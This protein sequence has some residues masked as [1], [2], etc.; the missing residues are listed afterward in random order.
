MVVTLRTALLAIVGTLGLLVVGFSGL[1]A[2]DAF[3]RYRANARFIEANDAS[4]VLLKFATN[5]AIERG[6]SNAPLHAADALPADQMREI[7][8]IRA[9]SDETLPRALAQLRR[10]PALAASLQT[11]DEL[12]DAYRVFDKFR[13]EVDQNLARKQNER[14]TDVVEKLAPMLT[15][16]IDRTEKVRTILEALVTSPEADLAQLVHVRT[17]VAEMA[18]Q[19]GRERDIF[20]GNISQ[21]APFTDD[22][23]RKVSEHRG[24]IELVWTALQAFRLRPDLPDAVTAAIGQVG[25]AYIQKLT[26][27]RQ[28]VLA[29]AGLG[30]YPLSGREWID[31]SGV[32]IGTIS[33]LTDVISAKAHDAAGESASAALRNLVLYLGLMAFGIAVSIFSFGIVTRYV[34]RPLAGVTSAMR[35]LAEGDTAV[36][37][38]GQ[39]RR[40]E[41]GQMAKAVDV[42][43]RNMIEADRLRADREDAERRAE[44]EKRATMNR[45]ADEFEA[46]VKGIVQSVSAA[47][48]E[49]RT[50]AQSM[51]T[52]AEQTEHRS[53]VVATAAEHASGNVEAVAAAAQE[54]SASVA[55]VGRQ[56]GESTG[57][58]RLA[59]EDANRTNTQ[60]QTLAEA[61][62]KIG[63]VVKLINDIAGQTNLLALN[64]TIEAARA[65]EAG[66]GFAVVASE[67]KTL[68]SQTAKATD[69][70]GGL[71][72][73]IQHA[74]GES[75][76]AIR[77]VGRTIG[78]TSEIATAIASAI[79]EQTA[80]ATEIARNVEHA[81][82][83]TTEVST[84]IAGVTKTAT[85]TRAAAGQVLSAA[86]ALSRQSD[87]LHAQVDAFIAK[88]RAA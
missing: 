63:D 71:I 54:L 72:K 14:S 32:A 6:A 38:P 7:A 79:E 51:S 31:Q 73:A 35:R 44:A 34:V 57:I 82:T 84:H 24:Q 2:Y 10:I 58:A 55:E 70:I 36:A 75:V 1:N 42:F 46:G 37:I 13:R 12:E 16:V 5:L 43:K 80:A 76:E 74:T 4:E 78:R 85:D 49:L 22:D 67:V 17:L 62:G 28:A 33:R 81:S 47:S 52:A 83:G 59:V 64:A 30:T 15:G 77:S 41:L 40:D 39:D 21:R 18:E 19:A 45:M 86:D 69:E 87:T 60:V 48:A 25:E 56:V 23:M 29:A 27:T 68:A 66:K 53:T 8:R 3:S 20:A 26:A 61:V 11:V 88:V 9:A 50:T 65:G